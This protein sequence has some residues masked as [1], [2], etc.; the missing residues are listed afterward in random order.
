MSRPRKDSLLLA[1]LL[2]VLVSNDASAY[3]RE[4]TS[5]L[6]PVAWKN[7]RVAMHLFVDA[8][9]G[10]LTADQYMQAATAGATAWSLPA[11][12][13]TTV[14]MTMVAEP[15][16]IADV[17]YDKMNN[18]SFRTEAWCS[19]AVPP[20]DVRDPTLCYSH[21]ALAVTTIFKNKNT[22]EILDADIAINGVDFAW[23]DLVGAPEQ[24]AGGAVDFQNMLTHELGH[25]LGL[26]HSCSLYGQ[27]RL[28]DNTGSLELDCGSPELPQAIADSTM[29]PSVSLKD[30]AR[31]SLEADD[32]QG[33]CDIY[34]PPHGGG[35][36]IAEDKGGLAKSIPTAT[37]VLA[38]G[39]LAL[40]YRRGRI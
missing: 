28:L 29:F 37:L 24:A 38:I 11:V 7:P 21:S 34:T 9:P 39:L 3:V 16:V 33:I 10:M 22:G 36:A 20:E 6:I 23:G 27:D 5:T 15:G 13:C 2:C 4:V 26:D 18:I 30:T 8:P 17:A 40:V 12:S 14:Q 1:G 25:V 31:R 19:P 32:I 35:C